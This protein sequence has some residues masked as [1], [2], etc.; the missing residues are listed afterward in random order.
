MI[1]P[2]IGPSSAPCTYIAIIR[3]R[4]A[5]VLESRMTVCASGLRK[6]PARPCSTRNSTISFKVCAAPHSIEANVNSTTDRI[7]RLRMPILS[8]SHPASGIATAEAR[9]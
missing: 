2:M 1:G 9:T 5:G 8:T 4:S 3:G 6:A 7:I